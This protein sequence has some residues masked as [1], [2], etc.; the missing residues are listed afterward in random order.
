LALESE[1]ATA[2]AMR[3]ARAFD[4]Q[5]DEAQALLRRILTPAAKYW[6]C[7]RG[8]ALAAEAMEVLGGNGFVEEGPLARVYRQMPLNSIWEGAGNIMCLDVLR[9]VAR[10][11]RCI[12][13]LA[14]ELEPARSGNAHLDAHIAQLQRELREPLQH[15]EQAR[16]LTQ[17]I[18]L[19]VQGALLVRF[20]EDV[21][22][23]A[24]CASRLAQSHFAGGAFGHLPS[25]TDCVSIIRRAWPA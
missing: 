13:A 24:F 5:G 10:D 14:A 8:P 18:A 2:L 17:R 12:E 9:A 20:S 25:G 23:R 19:A 11:A 4:A 21:V 6:I 1:A 16:G 22:A 3:L 7:K 15:E